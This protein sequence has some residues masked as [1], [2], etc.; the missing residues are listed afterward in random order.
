MPFESLREKRTKIVATVGPACGRLE[1]LKTLIREGVNVFRINASHSSPPELRRWLHLVREASR[2]AGRHVAT[3]VDLQGPRIRTGR[4]KGGKPIVLEKGKEVSILP[5]SGPGFDSVITTPCRQFAKILGK[6]DRILLDNGLMEVEVIRLQKNRIVGRILAGG[7]LGE[8]K[9]INLPNVRVDFP[10]VTEKD[11]QDLSIATAMNADYIGLSFVRTEEDIRTVKR[12]MK[13][14]GKEIPVIAKIEKPQAV[15]RF[16]S[17]LKEAD[18][19]MVARGDLGIEMGVEKVPVTQKHLI[20]LANRAGIPVITATQMLESMMENPR[21]TRAEASDIANAVFDGTDAVM[22]SGET[23]MGK[24]PAESVRTMA[25][26]IRETEEHIRAEDEHDRGRFFRQ[27][28]LPVHAI[29]VAACDAVGDLKA[30]AIVAFTA[31]GGTAMLVSKLRPAAKIIAMAPSEKICRRL[32]LFW[33]VTPLQM[34]YRR[35]TDAMLHEGER[36]ILRMALLKPGDSTVIVSGR[37]ALPAARYMV[38]IHKIG[39]R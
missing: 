20:A 28:D 38:K 14:R 25:R 37:Q 2:R 29:T 11:L 17:I 30:K 19:I 13:K 16:N 27:R 18:G 15:E 33:G 10:A 3:L 36:S 34:N 7:T 22:L 39:E 9:G 8:N 12:W 35:S 1:D 23:A 4:L 21:P 32:N 31:S 26:I 5:S 6:G 24:Y